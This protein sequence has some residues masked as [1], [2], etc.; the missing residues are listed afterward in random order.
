M[1]YYKRM[2]SLP[3]NRDGKTKDHNRRGSGLYDSSFE[4]DSCGVGLVAQIH[5][6][7]SHDLVVNALAVLERLNHRGAQ[8]IDTESGDGAGIVTQIPHLFFKKATALLQIALPSP[9][10]YGIGMTFLP[11]HPLQIQEIKLKIMQVAHAEGFE[12]I[13]WRLVPIRNEILSPKN[14]K[15]CPRIEQFFV[16]PKAKTDRL[17]RDLYLLRKKLE[18]SCI[19]NEAQSHN[20]LS[21]EF[22]ISSLS[23]QTLVYKGQLQGTQL[24]RFYLDLQDPDF[25][26]AIAMVHARFCTNT[27]PAWALAHPFRYTCHNGEINTIRGNLNWM[28]A[29]QMHLN[30][31]IPVI[32]NPTQSDSASLDNAVEFLIMNGY[33]LPHAL[34]RLIPEPW[35]HDTEMTDD[36]KSFYEYQ[37]IHMEPWDGPALLGFTDGRYVGAH[38]DR[39]GLRP[40]RYQL[41]QDNLFVLA[42]EAGVLPCADEKIREKGRLK[43]GQMILIDTLEGK[44]LLDGEIKKNLSIQRPYK[45]WVSQGCISLLNPNS[46]L[47][48]SLEPELL[49]SDSLSRIQS[50]FK[51][52]REEINSI[53]R[54]MSIHGE[55]PTSSMGNDTPLA[56]LSEKPQLLFKYFK[57]MFAQVTNPPIDP[58]RELHVMSLITHLG[59][60]PNFI[61]EGPL[62][63]IQLR[64]ENPILS[65]SELSQIRETTHPSLKSKT[66]S[67]LFKAGL[68]PNELKLRLGHLCEEAIAATQEGNTLLILSDRGLDPDLA[69]IPT[70]LGVSTV[71]H[72]L[73]RRSLRNQTSIILESGEPR[74]IHHFACL[75]GY[76]ANLICPYLA[77]QTIQASSPNTHEACSKYISAANKG[78]LKILSKMGISTL[79]SY[80]GSQLFE[81]IGIQSEV[82]NS[83]FPGT[84]SRIEGI[85]LQEIAEDI[86]QTHSIAFQ[87]NTNSDLRYGGD[88]HYRVDGE[89]HNW[90]PEAIVKLQMASRN[91]DPK[92]YKE[93]SAWA[94][95]ED[96]P[97]SALKN[98]LEFNFCP[99]PLPL[100]EIEGAGSIVKR[101][102]TG[103]MSFGALG[104]ESHETIAIAMNRIGA[105]SNSGEGGEDPQRFQRLENGDWKNSYIKQI[106]SARFGVTTQYL[107]NALELQIKMAQ[108]AKPGEGGQLPGHKVDEA[109]AN[110][111]FSTPGIDLISPPPHH[112]IYSIEDLA[113]LIFDLK[114]VNPT[115]DISVKLVAEAGVGTIAVGVAKAHAHKILISGDCGGTGASSL[116]SIKNAGIPWEL[117]LAEAHQTLVMN[118][119]RS[120]VRLETD[121]QLKTG[122]DVVIAALLGADEFGFS[123]APLVTL[124][125]IMMRKCHLNT[126]P[127]GIATQDPL[128][129]KKFTGAPEHVINYLFFVAEEVREWM[130]KLGFRKFSEMIGS[131]E[132]LKQKSPRDENKASQLKLSKLLFKPARKPDR[133]YEKTPI[134]NQE[135]QNV[136]DRK[137][138]T[139]SKPALERGER[140]S[141]R[142]PIQNTDRATGAM[143]SG[144]WVRR[145]RSLASTSSLGKDTITARFTGS[146]GQSFGAFLA[147]GITFILEGESNDYVGKGLSGGKI[148][149]SHPKKSQ[150]KSED[151]V[152]V[153]NTCLYGATQGQVYLSG[154]AGERFA[155]RNS[156][157]LAVVEG[158]GDHT[159][160]YM[161]GGVVVVLGKTG[162]NFSAGMS[163]GIAYVLDE[164]D[165]FKKACNTALVEIEIVKN[166]DDVSLLKMLIKNHAKYTSSAKANK[167][168]ENWQKYGPLFKRVIPKAFK[169]LLMKPENKASLFFHQFS[170]EIREIHV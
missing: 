17:E 133:S 95:H 124:G 151:T 16:T 140:V 87:K 28:R 158:T 20:I 132:K 112:D 50:F 91:N 94:N 126:C 6:V 74:E 68:G 148:I 123:T 55:E 168:Q 146:S 103:A 160:E 51:Y 66:L 125:C 13:G 39:N 113:Q 36:L 12:V 164:N 18:V 149:I 73:I 167:I 72:E 150:F 57:Q 165:E 5:G 82:I 69:A 156:G 67:L 154:L 27:F 130:A 23:S 166:E 85:G 144:E 129:R 142:L 15:A 108:G 81:A 145:Y 98:L 2:N 97:P 116:S 111:R 120:R 106:A 137:L 34:L 41:T 127:V 63:S 135:I 43:S 96:A 101:F 104:K 56:I 32:L 161:T 157:A 128:L 119:L 11:S 24:S 89:R 105:K 90:N 7:K 54:P 58:I 84:I 117:G 134:R 1:G 21:R 46:N 118:D 42:S 99:N 33:S 93:F 92:T 70:L 83:Y 153:G 49:R 47:T 170:N 10:S 62:T 29:R 159:C 22:Y 40:C 14:L 64:I 45:R 8:G 9:D 102:T 38:L 86:L 60:K 88:I 19:S 115:A 78:L 79:Q 80:C 141:I 48:S 131:V 4:K 121:G 138:I 147:S 114:N 110:L 163:G 162:M 76:G 71:H 53:I 61:T 65:N 100:E 122:R 35:A 139:L 52:T 143:L 59:A 37:S 26:S 77:F 152:L 75:F 109:I 136:L 25:T 30:E 31:K 44:I 3:P 107:V 169:F 155:V